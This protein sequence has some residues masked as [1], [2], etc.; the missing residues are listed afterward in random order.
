MCDCRECVYAEEEVVE[1]VNALIGE[2]EI[3]RYSLWGKNQEAINWADL[4][5]VEVREFK[6]GSFY[7]LIEEASPDCYKFNHLIESRLVDKFGIVATVKTE[8]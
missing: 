2:I 4:G 3:D 6:D 7:I 1:I 8:W 5:A